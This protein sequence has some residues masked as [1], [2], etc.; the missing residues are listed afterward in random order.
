MSQTLQIPNK[1]IRNS[2][3]RFRTE[4]SKVNVTRP[5]EMSNRRDFVIDKRLA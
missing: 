4:R 3:H 2:Q 1:I 5:T